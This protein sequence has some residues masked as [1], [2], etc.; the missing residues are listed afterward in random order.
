[1]KT[2]EQHSET[3]KRIIAQIRTQDNASTADPVYTVQER[4][5]IYYP[6][7][8]NS[9]GV[10]LDE[11]SN[12]P[13]A[14]ELAEIEAGNEDGWSRWDYED[15]WQIVQTFL[16]LEG[17]NTYI[18]TQAHRHGEPLR[19]YV[20]SAY[21]NTEIQALRWLLGECLSGVPDPAGLMVAVR[22]VVEAYNATCK[23]T[24]LLNRSM[25][26]QRLDAALRRLGEVMG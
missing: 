5:R 19:L 12:E 9:E 21:R 15:R 24:D 18:E 8:G 2:P 14:E 3:I 26:E 20:D 6:Y 11:D 23:A 17:A 25:D 13:N 22:E 10:W 1:M 16:T 7:D 4:K